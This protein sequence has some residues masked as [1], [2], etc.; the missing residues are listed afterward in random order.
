[1]RKFRVWLDKNVPGQSASYETV[2]MPDGSTDA[3]CEAAC[4]DVLDVMIGNE[5][6][7]GWEETE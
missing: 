1:M 7:T 6:D 5:L 4:R 3:E 2:E